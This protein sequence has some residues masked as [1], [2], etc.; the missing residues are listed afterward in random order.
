MSKKAIG[1]LVFVLLL[2]ITI[3]GGFFLYQYKSKQIVTD[4][5]E[6]FSPVLD[7][8]FTDLAVDLEGKVELFGVKIAPI[9]YQDV[10][11]IDKV[12][13]VSG[14]ALSLI[15]ASNWMKGGLPEKIDLQFL[16]V[17]F[18]IDSDFMLPTKQEGPLAPNVQTLWGLACTEQTDI[19]A[20]AKELGLLRLQ[21]DAQVKVELDPS[22]RVFKT[23]AAVSVP[24]LAKALFEFQ[25]NSNVSLDFYDR[26]IM[27]RAQ[28]TY[29]SLNVADVGFN[30]KRTKFC[31]KQEDIKESSYPDFFKAIVQLKMLGE[32]NSVLPELEES[33]LAFFKP[34]VSVVLR[35]KPDEPLYLPEAFDQSF[36][37]FEAKNLKLSINN[38]PV[39]TH[40][41]PML[42]GHSIEILVEENEQEA[43]TEIKET[44]IKRTG[45]K[46][47]ARF[48]SVDFAELFSLQGKKIR[49]QTNVGKELEGVLLEVDED[50][51]IM[52]R[53][54]EQGVVTYPIDKKNIATIKVFR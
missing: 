24:S 11:L 40:Y 34:G 27:S 51:I 6:Q 18:D 3:A 29:A 50:K 47:K 30:L 43:L 31:A 39:S 5:I 12:D 2:A 9:G 41:L 1:W 44:V 10:V 20:L 49:L 28:I 33:I 14:S 19:H 35:L 45:V 36:D 38:Q 54:V 25:I 13:I 15:G 53:R 7:I 17:I 4:L 23:A 22:G 52:R 32:K 26:S 46:Q 16:S 42:R 8:S 48:R 37:L 21:I